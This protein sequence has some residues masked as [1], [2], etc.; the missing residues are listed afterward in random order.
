MAEPKDTR[1]TS[2]QGYMIPISPIAKTNKDED[3]NTNQIL[4]GQIE[5]RRKVKR[6]EYEKLARKSFILQ[7]EDKNNRPDEEQVA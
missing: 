4:R 6:K 1:P 5:A 7:K 2:Q 3:D